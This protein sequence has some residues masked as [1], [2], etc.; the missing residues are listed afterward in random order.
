MTLEVMTVPIVVSDAQLNSQDVEVAV[1]GPDGA[2]RL[3]IYTGIAEIVHEQYGPGTRRDTYSFLIGP[4]LTHNQFHRAIATAAVAGF[5]FQ[6]DGTGAVSRQA[7][8]E[9]IDADWDDESGR[10]QVRF[11][12]VAALS[13]IAGPADSVSIARVS[14]T[15][16]IVAEIA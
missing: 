15:V 13:T 11:E 10:T 14:Y 7:I 9:N 12:A 5:A 8:V 16:S 6:D 3:F 1:S 4:V 2:N